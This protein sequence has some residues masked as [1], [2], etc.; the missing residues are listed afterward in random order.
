MASRVR[1]VEIENFKTFGAKLHVDLGHPAVLIGPNNAGKTTL[2]QAL[3]LWSQGVKSWCEKRGEP[4]KKEARE[5]VSAGINRLNILDVP[6]LETRF[7]WNGTRVRKGNTPIEMRINVGVEVNG[8]VKDCRLI[9]TYRDTEV[10]YC[11]PCHQTIEDDSLLR[12]ASEMRFHLLYPMSGIMSGVSADTEE[13]LLPDGRLN[14]LLGQGQTAQVLRN[15]C[16]KVVEQDKHNGTQDWESVT[17]LVKRIFMVDLDKPVF[18]ENRGVL[19]MRYNEPGVDSGLDISLA[20][21]GLQQTLLILAYLYWHKN[22][23]LL[24]DEPDA[25]LE[26]LRQRQIYDILRHAAESNGSQVV[27]ATHSEVILEEAADTNLTLILRG[28]AVDMARRQDMSHALRT[29]GVEQYYKALAMPRI[30]YVEG[31]S[32]VE[33]LR[34]LAEKLGHS[35]AG[36]LR[37]EINCHYTQNTGPE[38]S[39]ENRLDRKSG[40]FGDFRPHFFTVKKF[41]PELKGIALF[42][43][44]GRDRKDEI[45]DDMAV[46]WWKNYELENYFIT[47]DTLCQFAASVFNDENS[48]FESQSGQFRETVDQCL[49]DRFFNSDK[50]QLDEFHKISG[51]MKRQI[52]NQRKMSA[53]AEDVF[54]RFASEHKQPPLL[55]KG[56]F[57]KLIR[58]VAPEDIPA[59]VSEKLDLLVKYLAPPER[60]QS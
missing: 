44:D 59:E 22:S 52:L 6:V 21:R 4:Q 2:I 38:D 26:I 19:V 27:I 40:G 43:S 8:I 1:H 25:H 24:V 11:K 13:T 55:G 56:E 57:Y 10:I 33:M 12:S 32:D 29:F 20:G 15:I 18:N 16:Y 35:A 47:P 37:G 49:L 14:V 50:S 28:K 42:D 60:E 9:F 41:V 45:T 54:R 36:V 39:L 51:G 31:S 17:A 3:S 48:L 23:V 53:F 7:L 30:L 58:Y 5:R 46:V 34:A